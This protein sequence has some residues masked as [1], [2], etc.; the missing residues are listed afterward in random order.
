M[1]TFKRPVQADMRK[2]ELM[3]VVTPLL[4]AAALAA[5]P[6]GWR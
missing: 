6:I 2:Q 4:R 3:D 1:T 5:P